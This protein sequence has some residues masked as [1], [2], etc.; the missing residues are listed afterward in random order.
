MM[1]SM[2][3]KPA[4][5]NTNRRRR[6]EKNNALRNVSAAP[7]HPLAMALSNT[8]EHHSPHSAEDYVREE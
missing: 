6:H 1:K 4:A 5:I 3:P 8:D 7:L 2:N